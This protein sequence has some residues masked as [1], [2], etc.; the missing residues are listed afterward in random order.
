M[1]KFK[2]IKYWLKWDI[3]TDNTELEAITQY[4]KQLHQNTLKKY[5]RN[6]K[7]PAHLQLIK[8]K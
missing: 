7:I 2:Y 1:E 3:T 8:I 6:A 5:Q 4:C